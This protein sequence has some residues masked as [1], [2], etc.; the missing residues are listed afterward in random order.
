MLKELNE[1]VK[2]V[3]LRMNRIKTHFM[4]N[5]WCNG[6]NIRLDGSLITE[7]S[8]Y[9]YF[10]RSLNMENNMKEKLDRRKKAP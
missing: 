1:A 4:K 6:E 10:G 9:V 8:S 3:E 2:K 5:Q 7:T